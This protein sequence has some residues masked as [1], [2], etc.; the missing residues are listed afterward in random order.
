MEGLSLI[1]LL[2]ISAGPYGCEK[3]GN[4]STHHIFCVYSDSSN[5]S[6]TCMYNSFSGNSYK[7]L[8]QF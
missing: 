5:T 1:G 6:V 7:Q 3:L 8:T 2:L 4:K